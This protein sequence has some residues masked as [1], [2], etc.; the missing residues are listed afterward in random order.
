MVCNSFEGIYAPLC[1]ILSLI[2]TSFYVFIESAVVPPVQPTASVATAAVTTT[3]TSAAT[4]VQNGFN[5]MDL[6]K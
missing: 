6:G 4:P 3:S 5:E 1:D 2:T